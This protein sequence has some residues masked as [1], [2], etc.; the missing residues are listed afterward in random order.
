MRGAG[1]ISQPG[2]AFGAPAG[3]LLVAGRAGT[4]ELFNDMRYGAAVA[5]DTLDEQ[6]LPVHSQPGITVDHEDLRSR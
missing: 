2:V 3:Q 4:A 1:P 5:D 6:A